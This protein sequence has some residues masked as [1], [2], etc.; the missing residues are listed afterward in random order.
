MKTDD[1]VALLASEADVVRP[2]AAQRRFG[3]A[4]MAGL[5]LSA[6]LMMTTLGLRPDMVEATGFGMFWVKLGLPLAVAGIALYAILRIARPGM[7]APAAP[8]MIAAALLSIWMLALVVLVQSAPAERAGLVFGETWAECPFNILF[9]SLPMFAAAIWA[10]RGL[11]PTRPALAGA[12]AGLLAGGSGAFVYALHCPELA[13]PF[14]G[15]WYVLGMALPAAIG[16]VVGR[17]VLRW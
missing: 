5:P 1:L 9:L 13:A 10:L 8:V 16:A 4:M 17:A 6:L 7:R 2:G 3:L 12:T 11:A 14:I 15:I